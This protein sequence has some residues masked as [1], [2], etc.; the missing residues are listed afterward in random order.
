MEWQ[1]QGETFTTD[2]PRDVSRMWVVTG[3]WAMV[4]TF[5]P[6]AV[7]MRSSLPFAAATALTD[8]CGD[9]DLS[10]KQGGS[11]SWLH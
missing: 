3:L 2:V 11:F 7:R 1:P 8:M 10:T 4:C 9:G 5:V 6:V